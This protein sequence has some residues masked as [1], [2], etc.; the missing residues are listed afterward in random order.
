MLGVSSEAS[1]EELKRAYTAKAFKL[2]PDRHAGASADRRAA[3]EWRMRELNASWAVLRDARR[4]KAYD[5]ELA[6]QRRAEQAHRAE[7]VWTPRAAS[8]ADDLPDLEPD[9]VLVS[10]T[11]HT[12]L[13]FA[14]VAVLA[15]V[16]LTILIFSAYAASDGQADRPLL[17]TERAPVGSCVEVGPMPRDPDE[18]AT[19]RPELVEVD[20]GRVGASRVVAKVSMNQVCPSGTT[21]YPVVEENLAVC[22]Q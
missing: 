10:A 5:D 18:A 17:T 2:H 14:P 15:V 4:R 9:D 1:Y 20:C 6:R 16:L 7:P 21:A 8:V 3:S 22:L 12:V 11:Q 19:A 13:R